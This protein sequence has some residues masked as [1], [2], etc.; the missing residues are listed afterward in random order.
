MK[1]TALLVIDVQKALV[2]L[3]PFDINEVIHNIKSLIKICRENNTEVIFVQHNGEIGSILEPNSDGWNI[4]DEISPNKNEK[5][6]SKNY[7][8][9]FR[10]TDL[11]EYLDSKDITNLIITG[12]QTEY[13]IDTTCKVAF[14]YGFNII[15]PEK[16][17]TTFNNGNILAK[18]LYDYYNFT[19]FKD[20]FTTVE[21]LNDTIKRLTTTN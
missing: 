13:C 15:T 7:N 5:V 20:R 6:L 4:Y 8:S 18:D 2:K 9:A 1:N 3:N 17:N 11:K 14:E 19:I 12:M 10:Q 16:T 21:N